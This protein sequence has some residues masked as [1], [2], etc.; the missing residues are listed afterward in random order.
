MAIMEDRVAFDQ[1]EKIDHSSDRM[2]VP[3]GW[4]VRTHLGK[5]SYAVYAA[6]AAV[7]V[8]DKN[9]EWKL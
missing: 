6:I 9:H 4:I 1:W 7:V 8:E 3:N 5:D 2:K